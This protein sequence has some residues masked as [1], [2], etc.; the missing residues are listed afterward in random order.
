[1]TSVWR[2]KAI[3]ELHN[4]IYYKGMERDFHCEALI[5]NQGG[6]S[7]EWVVNSLTTQFGTAQNLVLGQT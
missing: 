7:I 6:P 1:M 4:G 2:P 3:V 5:V